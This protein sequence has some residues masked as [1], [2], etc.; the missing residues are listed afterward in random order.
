MLRKG[1]L[2]AW[3]TSNVMNSSNYLNHTHLWALKQQTR[4]EQIGNFT[5]SNKNILYLDQGENSVKNNGFLTA[6]NS[7][8]FKRIE[9]LRNTFIKGRTYYVKANGKSG[10]K[11]PRNRN[12]PRHLVRMAGLEPARP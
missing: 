4:Y 9:R 5:I 8:I 1:F 7:F 12:I 3:H 6:S 2:I 10:N 11:K